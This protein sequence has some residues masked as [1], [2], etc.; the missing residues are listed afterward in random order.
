MRFF[1]TKQ[2]GFRNTFFAARSRGREEKNAFSQDAVMVRYGAQFRTTASSSE[3]RL[4]NVR[5]PSRSI[6]CSSEPSGSL[7]ETCKAWQGRTITIPLQHR[8]GQRK[9]HFSVK[10]DTKNIKHSKMK[11][12]KINSLRRTDPVQLAVPPSQRRCSSITIDAA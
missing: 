9:T 7:I 11:R 2:C 1:L 4:Q 6:P 3:F 10:T 5:S 12:L 8:R